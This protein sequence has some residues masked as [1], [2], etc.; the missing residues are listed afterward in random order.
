M[1]CV[2][3]LPGFALLGVR[4]TIDDSMYKPYSFIHN[5]SIPAI[6]LSVLI[7]A[8]ALLDIHVPQLVIL[9]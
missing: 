9:C 5:R 4:E 8:V 6:D 1:F 3:N 2:W 7:A